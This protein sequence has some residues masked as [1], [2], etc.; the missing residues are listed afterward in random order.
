MQMMS[1]KCYEIFWEATARNDISAIKRVMDDIEDVSKENEHGWSA[2]I[3]AAY[4]QNRDVVELLLKNG[5]NINSTNAKGTSVFMYG[6]TKSLHTGVYDFL[7]FL[8]LHGADINARD[9]KKG[10][11]VLQYVEEEGDIEM[12]EYLKKN[13]AE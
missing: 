5:V 10:W 13:G 7:D 2:I 3:M 4:N 11:S 1:K 6:K 9:K 12:A 8:L